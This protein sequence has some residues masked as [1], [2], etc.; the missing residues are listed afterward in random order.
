MPEIDWIGDKSVY[1]NWRNILP[2]IDFVVDL[3]EE[4]YNILNPI[5]FVSSDM[6]SF[7]RGFE[8]FYSWKRSYILC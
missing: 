1:E 3:S 6:D 8:N 5:G 2:G 4:Y 7:F